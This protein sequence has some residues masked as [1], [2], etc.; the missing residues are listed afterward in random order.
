MQ[1]KAMHKRV[2][3]PVNQSSESWIVYCGVIWKVDAW[4]I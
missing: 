3:Q 1:C 4:G 2:F